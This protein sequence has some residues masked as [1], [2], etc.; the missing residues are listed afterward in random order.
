MQVVQ[1]LIWT[2]GTCKSACSM[3]GKTD[4]V[5]V[6]TMERLDQVHLH[7]S[8][9]HVL[10]FKPQQSAKQAGAL[11]R[12]YSNSLLIGIRN[13]YMSSRQFNIYTLISDDEIR[14]SRGLERIYISVGADWKKVLN[15]LPPPPSPHPSS[16]SSLLLKWVSIFPY[17]FVG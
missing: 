15:G 14:K 8:I 10:G 16:F 17:I 7:P 12:S 1:P 2:S 9:K 3:S 13:I 11:P 5:G 6:T 4:H